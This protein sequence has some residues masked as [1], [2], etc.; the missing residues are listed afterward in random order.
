MCDTMVLTGEKA[1]DGVTVFGKNSDREPNEAQSIA[2]YPAENHA[3]G[4]K[5]RCTYIEIPQVEHTYRVL[6]SKPFWMWGAEMGANEHGLVIGNEAVFSKVPGPKQEALIGM[7][8]LRLGLERAA[9]APQA[10][11]VITSLLEQFGQGGHSGYAHPT[12]Y[13][14]SFLIADAGEAWILETVERHWAAR[15]VTGAASISNCLTLG[16]QLD[17][18]SPDLVNYARSQ[19]WSKGP[20][21]FDFARDYSDFIYT[22]FGRGRQRCQRSKGLLDAT[23]KEETIFAILSTLRDH[24]EKG[25]N[26]FRPDGNIFDFTIC[27]HAGFGP[28]RGTQTTGSMVA[29]L[30]PE[31]PVFFL[32]GTSAPCTSVFK[33]VWVDAGL[34]DLGS[35][36]TGSFDPATLFW[37]HELL[38]RATMRD[39]SPRMQL[40]RQQRDEMEARFVRQALALSQ[41]ATKEERLAFTASCFSEAAAAEKGWL[42]S[43]LKASERSRP[44]WFYNLAW[45][46]FNQQAKF[47]I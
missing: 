36:P 43:I 14:N 35:D 2:C 3:S 16:S 31:H 8:L 20:Q 33:P 32:T 37:Q 25:E 41:S 45:N 17:R 12:Y 38:H 11:E 42:E 21:E 4:A 22:N 10:I 24:G 9:T 5:L 15:R 23:G 19:G 6:L 29:Y 40:Y 27:A 28:V 1:A 39:Y 7:D 47:P 44:N 26:G 13:H 30:H 18:V 34:P 46:Q